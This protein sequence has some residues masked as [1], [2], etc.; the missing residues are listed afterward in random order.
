MFAQGGGVGS[1]GYY[2]GGPTDGMADQVP[3]IIDNNQP[4]PGS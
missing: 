1:N 3:A 2:L 4:A